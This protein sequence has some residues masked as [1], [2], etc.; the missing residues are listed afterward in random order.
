MGCGGTL[1]ATFGR[2]LCKRALRLFH[3]HTAPVVRRVVSPAATAVRLFS[4]GRAT[5]GVVV[6]PTRDAPWCVTAVSLLMSKALAA[7]ALQWAFR[8]HVRF[9][10]SQAAEFGERST[11]DTSGPRATD[12]MKWGWEDGPWRGPGR[13]GQTQLCYTLDTNVQG[14]QLLP[15]D[16]L[17][18]TPTQVVYQKPHTAVLWEREC[19]EHHTLPIDGPQCADR[20]SE[21][22]SC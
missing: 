8:G 14:F 18:H 15:D 21:P 12:T 11:F 13:D 19:V 16:A 22:V 4:R 7:L 2:L 10:H 17:R 9:R 5:T 1:S 20:G 3:L 6:A